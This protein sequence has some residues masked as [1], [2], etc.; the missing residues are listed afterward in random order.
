MTLSDL[1]P[2]GELAAPGR[3]ATR[4]RY[5]MC[6]P[7]HFA[8]TYAINPWMDVTVPVD[9]ERAIRQW[10][11]LRHTYLGLGHAVEVLDALP[12]QPDMVFAA[13]GGI[14]VGR[15]A[16]ASRFAHPQRQ[17][18]APAYRAWLQRAV[19]AGQLAGV[20][21]P[22]AT[23]EGEGD[24]LVVG[25]LILAGYGFR[26][27]L[28]AH[29][30]VQEVFGRPV[31]SLQ[32]VDPRFYHLDTA[33]AVLDDDTVAYWPG[34]FSPGSRAVL[35]RLFPGAVLAEE[36]DA[37][38]LGLNAVSDGQHVVLGTGADGLCATLRE[39][40]YRPVEVELSELRKAGGAAK[41]CTLELRP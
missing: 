21:D 38:V 7:T 23:V 6:P 34:A 13:N 39:R 30:Q 25:D 14:V 26:T 18:E 24:L 11:A 15:R 20:V 3:A 36:A 29:R 28:A 1:S 10:E 35:E 37:A 22:V 19:A 2:A 17:P 32:L 33:L 5:L 41:C 31:V 8:V 16:L 12:G 9:V 27:E 40:G 4:R